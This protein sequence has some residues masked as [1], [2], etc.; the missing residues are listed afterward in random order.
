[1]YKLIVAN[2]RF[3]L[4][5]ITIVHVILYKFNEPHSQSFGV[6]AQV[7]YECVSIL[8]LSSIFKYC[9][10]LKKSLAGG[11]SVIGNYACQTVN[12]D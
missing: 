9:T 11:A 8:I 5:C 6:G 2:I 12:F 1:M 4:L 7:C 10:N 3:F